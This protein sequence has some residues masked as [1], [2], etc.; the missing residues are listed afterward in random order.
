MYIDYFG[1]IDPAEPAGGGSANPEKKECLNRLFAQ[2]SNLAIF[3]GETVSC[4]R[5][6]TFDFFHFIFISGGEKNKE[7]IFGPTRGYNE[8]CA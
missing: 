6:L 7:P 5:L 1:R 8:A 2:Y 4:R 3:D